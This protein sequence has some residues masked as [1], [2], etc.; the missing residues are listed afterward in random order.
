MKNQPNQPRTPSVGYFSSYDRGLDT[1]LDMWPTI[2]AQVPDATLDIFYGWD[3][4]DAVYK[5][6]TEMM[7]WKWEM[8]NKFFELKDEGV[9]NHG[10]VS[11]E[12][13]AKVM[14]SLKVWAYPTEFNEISCMAAIKAQEAG[15]IP[16]TTYCYALKE[17]VVNPEFSFECTD[18]Y[19]NKES[20]AKFVENVA[21]ALKS[22]GFKVKKV[23]G[24][25]WEKVAQGWAEAL[26]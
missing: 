16:V 1:L 20:Q 9:T 23:D 8:T 7:K 13:L 26:A 14:K 22:E 17:T 25:Y 15:M 5:G 21:K 10:R 4:F 3:T 6:N 2:R 18:I 24:V 19:S 11:H 12:D